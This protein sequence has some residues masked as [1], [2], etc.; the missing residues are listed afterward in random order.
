MFSIELVIQRDTA[1]P[2]VEKLKELFAHPTQYFEQAASEVV[3]FLRDY[4]TAFEER[5]KG[6]HY[7]Q[8]P[9]SGEWA[10]LIPAGW[11]PPKVSDDAT[12]GLINTAP[13]FNLKVSGGTITSRSGKML[14]IP[15]I[16]E[17]KGL[18]AAEYSA[19]TGFS[20]FIP[21]GKNVLAKREGSEGYFLGPRGGMKKNQMV[22]GKNPSARGM[23]I[24]P[25]YALVASVT[26]APWPGAM[27]PDEQVQEV[28]KGGIMETLVEQLK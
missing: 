6:G 17:A 1:T 18:T 28:F 27:P 16:P 9:R 26:Q 15:L 20:L 4:H 19:E 2:R 3:D 24:V 13:D 5:W 7:M 14:T 22:G 11:Q 10:P 21:R 25:V 8:G 23:P 12:F